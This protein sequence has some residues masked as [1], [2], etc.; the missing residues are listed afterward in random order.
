MWGP[1]S[2]GLQPAEPGVS[3]TPPHLV[4]GRST[5]WDLS[6][7]CRHDSWH[8]GAVGLW[9]VGV[10][11]VGS[12]ACAK[13]TKMNIKIQPQCISGVPKTTLEFNDSLGGL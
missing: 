10:C 2:S 13:K 6:P 1:E 5:L 12:D 7:G 11:M 3:F 4:C 9:E 8:R